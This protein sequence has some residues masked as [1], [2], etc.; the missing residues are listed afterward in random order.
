MN[1]RIRRWALVLAGGRTR[2]AAEGS[3][4]IVAEP[5][6]GL[7]RNPIPLQLLLDSSDLAQL[8]AEE[9]L[10]W[11]RDGDTES[12]L[13]AKPHRC[14]LWSLSALAAFCV[15]TIALIAPL[16]FWAFP[17]VRSVYY[18]LVGCAAVLLAL[19]KWHRHFVEVLPEGVLALS[20]DNG[21]RLVKWEEIQQVIED[22]TLGVRYL[23][24]E[25]GDPKTEAWIPLFL[26]DLDG[27]LEDVLRAAPA[28]NP[29][30]RVS[31]ELLARRRSDRGSRER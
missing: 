6:I 8:T 19:L 23:D 7:L 15:L 4:V 26:Q 3:A 9:E 29:L 10:V 31:E 18:P 21:P 17:T 16:M 24:V 12:G 2:L 28:G 13:S 22:S 1:A 20:G 25:T 30:Y 14:S 11:G 5:S 27:F